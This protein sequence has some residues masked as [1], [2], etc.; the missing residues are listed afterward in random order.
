MFLGDH[1][2]RHSTRGCQSFFGLMWT[3]PAN[4]F[5]VTS[6][7]W[8]SCEDFP[9]G[10]CVWSRQQRWNRHR[11]LDFTFSW[12][13]Q[14]MHLIHPVDCVAHPK[15]SLG[16]LSTRN[17]NDRRLRKPHV[18]GTRCYVER[19]S[20]RT[21]HRFGALFHI[22]GLWTHSKLSVSRARFGRW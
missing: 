12:S 16:S 19:A 10:S 9:C 20:Q 5:D 18:C 21:Q 3:E 17:Q 6:P 4:V 7:L 22:F 15:A 11:K 2:S 8:E 13:T 14:K 1:V